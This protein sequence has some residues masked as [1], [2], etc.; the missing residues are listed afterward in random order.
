MTALCAPPPQ[1]LPEVGSVT[2]RDAMD[3]GSP[4]C[5]T[6]TID[7]TTGSA[8]FDFEG[9]GGCRVGV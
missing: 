6:V 2:A 8:V 7:R 1:G 5:L 9:T 4:I 3:D